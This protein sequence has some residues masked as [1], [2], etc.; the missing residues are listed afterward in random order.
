MKTKQYGLSKHNINW[1]IKYDWSK[2]YN[3]IKICLKTHYYKKI[4]P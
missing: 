4:N 2:N 3:I 1:E